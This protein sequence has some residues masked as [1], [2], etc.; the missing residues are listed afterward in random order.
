[1]QDG[2]EVIATKYESL[3]QPLQ[4]QPNSEEAFKQWQ[5]QM[6]QQLAKASEVTQAE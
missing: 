4:L 3:C 1:L 2:V 6:Q 5:T